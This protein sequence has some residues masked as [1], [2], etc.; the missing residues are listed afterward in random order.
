MSKDEDGTIVGWHWSFGDGLESN[1]RN[2]V[3]TYADP[4]HYDVSLTVT[5]NNG[6]TN[7]KTRRA[8]VKE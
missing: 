7:T 1:E 6:A 3:H 4:G 2:P 5:D 8:D